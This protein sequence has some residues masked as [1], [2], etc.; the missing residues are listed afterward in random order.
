MGD[1]ITLPAGCRAQARRNSGAGPGSKKGK[2]P[3]WIPGARA[4]I[5]GVSLPRKSAPQ[6]AA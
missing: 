2:G 5:G 1:F 4:G 6:A 3:G